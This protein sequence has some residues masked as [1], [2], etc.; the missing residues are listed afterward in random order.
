MKNEIKAQSA[1][2]NFIFQFLYQVVI[3]VIPL[4]TAPYLTRML[5][6]TALGVYSYTYSIAYYFV[7]FAMLGISRH[8]QRIIASRRND[9]LALRKTFWSL[10]AVHAAFSVFALAAYFLFVILFGGDYSTVYYIQAFYVTSA[11]FDITWLFYG[12]EN[13]QSVVIKNFLLKIV[14]CVL[15]FCLVKTSEDLWIYTLIMSCS[16]CAGQLVMLP[17]AIRFVKPVKFTWADAK[18]H[19]KPL[20][21]LFIAVV[22]A[23]LYTVFDKT[24]LGFMATK[25]DVAYYE[26]SNKIINIPKTIIGVICTVM[27]PRACASI[28][29]GD[30]KNAKKYMDYSLHFTCFLGLGAIFGLLG[31]SNLFAVLYYGE[32]FAV[33]GDVIIALSPNIFIIELGNIIRTQYMVPNHMDKQLSIC[34]IINAILNLALSIALISVLGI[35]GA[36]I[37]TIAAEVCGIIFQLILCRKFLPF[38]KVVVTMIPYAVFGAVMFGLIYLIRLFFNQSWWDLLLQVAVGAVVYCILCAV[39]LL[40]FSPIKQNLR[41]ILNGIFHRKKKAA[42]VTDGEDLVNQE[43]DNGEA[44]PASDAESG[45]ETVA[46][47]EENDCIADEEKR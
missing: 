27:F 46:P 44:E 39:Y 20:F 37:G 16:L 15:I 17:Q 34:Y 43:P 18:E 12:L 33:C 35:Y 2:K 1:K 31:I 13:F 47:E 21:V 8:G 11:L 9:K 14:E 19:F 23:T 22:A 7:I 32:S 5:G 6:D 38:K 40:V 26:Y 10:Y 4:V 36:V 3:L 30:I 28:A 24:L 29:K 41:N 25:E 42:T 45:E